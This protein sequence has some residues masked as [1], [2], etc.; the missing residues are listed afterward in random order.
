MSVA[1]C[2]PVGWDGGGSP[3]GPLLIGNPFSLQNIGELCWKT[4]CRGP[5]RYTPPPKKKNMTVMLLGPQISPQ[6]RAAST[7]LLYSSRVL[8]Q[9][10]VK[11]MVFQ[12]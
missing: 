8:A 4:L 10:R 9:K 7:L 2:G 1:C 12:K 6:Q 3:C 5:L 11:T